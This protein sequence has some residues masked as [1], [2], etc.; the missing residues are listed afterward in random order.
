M[1]TTTIMLE[2]LATTN[3]QKIYIL[4][5][6]SAA[7][8]LCT[9]DIDEVTNYLSELQPGIQPNLNINKDE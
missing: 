6:P 5:S 1:K 4:R 9:D 2:L 7:V 3:S 8:L